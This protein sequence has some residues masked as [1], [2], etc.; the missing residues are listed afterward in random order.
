MKYNYQVQVTVLPS[1]I[2]VM[3]PIG[4]DYA[5][6]DSIMETL[7]IDQERVHFSD[8][9]CHPY[10]QLITLERDTER[11]EDTTAALEQLADDYLFSLSGE[12]QA[13]PRG[14]G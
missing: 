14:T 8:Y 12:I 13:D 5:E 7:G 9:I 3:S 6:W 10:G 2:T 1:T 11:V 4:W